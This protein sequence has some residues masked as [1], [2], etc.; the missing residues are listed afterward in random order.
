M[1]EMEEVRGRQTQMQEKGPG[2]R[3]RKKQ[4]PNKRKPEGTLARRIYNTTI[5]SL[6]GPRYLAQIPG[7]RSNE[8]QKPNTRNIN[9]RRAGEGSST[10]HV[11]EQTK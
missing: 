7:P 3:E 8:T 6:R 9:T 2:E 11:R 10:A 5:T 1:R 4:S